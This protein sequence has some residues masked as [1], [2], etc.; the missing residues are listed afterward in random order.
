M[1]GYW[2]SEAFGR[3]GF[4]TPSSCVDRKVAPIL[5]DD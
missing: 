3:A 4:P 1:F 5:A 2:I